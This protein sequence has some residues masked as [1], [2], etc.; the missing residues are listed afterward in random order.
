[1]SHIIPFVFFILISAGFAHAVTMTEAVGIGFANNPDLMAL[2]QE[3]ELAKAQLQKARLLLP[4]NP[5]IAGTLSKKEKP[6][7]AGTGN[8]TNY[9][10]TLSQEFEVAGQR[11][12]RIGLAE[13]NLSRVGFQIRDRER[14]LRYAI[15]DAFA[16]AISLKNRE[17]LTRRVV[18]FQEELVDFTRIKYRAGSVSGLEVNLSEIELGKAK[19]DL[20]SVERELKEALLGLQGLMGVR[21]NPAFTVH[22]ELSPEKFRVPAK[23]ELMK[24]SAEMRP[25]MKV[26]V[27]E[28]DMSERAIDLAKRE[29]IPNVVLGGFQTR[30]EERFDRGVL[31][32]VAIPLFDR[33]QAERKRAEAL[34][35]QARIRRSGLEKTL[36]REIDDAYNNLSL[37]LRELALFQKEIM[38]KSM[39]TL[40]LLNFAYKEGKISFFEVRTAQKDTLE[41]QFAYLDTVLQAERWL[42]AVE[43][44]VGGE[45]E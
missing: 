13:K 28:V 4:A 21:S 18:G 29:A 38:N 16:R 12:V 42:H 15:K 11:G 40:S 36:E 33:R 43:R 3:A 24:R 10:L 14:L 8:Y 39:E 32:S 30:D 34:A 41:I 26:S 20:F 7:E 17:E 5:L 37:T 22:G 23:E 31:M 9:S 44:A 2:R 45:I 35:L 6:S 1:M 19:K 25:D 27:A